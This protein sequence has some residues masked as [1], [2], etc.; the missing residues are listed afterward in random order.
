M[1]IFKTPKENKYRQK[2]KTKGTN[3]KIILNVTDVFVKAHIES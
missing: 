2:L 3:S 1:V